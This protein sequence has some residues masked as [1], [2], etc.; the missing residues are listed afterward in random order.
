[1]S[2]IIAEGAPVVFR[3]MAA[4]Q[5]QRFRSKLSAA[6]FLS[7]YWYGNI[8]VFVSEIPYAD[9]N[10][11]YRNTTLKQ[12]VESW[13]NGRKNGDGG[14]VA[15]DYLFS[16][17][18][19]SD[20]PAIKDTFLDVREY[21]NRIPL[22][23]FPYEPQ[24]FFGDAGTGAPHHWHGSAI[25]VLAWGTKLWAIYPPFASEYDI[26][27][28]L[29]FFS[30]EVLEIST[31]TNGPRALTCTQYAGDVVLAP[32]WWG[33]STLNAEP[34]I[35]VAM[36]MEFQSNL[37]SFR[38]TIQ[39]NFNEDTKHFKKSS[40]APLRLSS[41]APPTRDHIRSAHTNLAYRQFSTLKYN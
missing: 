32:Y 28:A 16:T 2:E 9:P 21:A 5:F 27:P 14:M 11:A 33:H 10:E 13:Y 19:I 29:D 34:T 23:A 37:Q 8:S 41:Q 25:N 24:F 17:Q 12:M 6:N 3:G 31:M 39:D 38:F 22:A 26:K 40:S 15:P 30:D 35:G 4:R 18:F 20:N 1:M 7:T 36:E